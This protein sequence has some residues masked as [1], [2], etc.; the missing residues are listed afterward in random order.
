MIKRWINNIDAGGLAKRVP[1][2]SAGVSYGLRYDEQ[3]EGPEIVLFAA[4][5]DS[6]WV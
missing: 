6:L 1:V 2:R 3:G 4:E 5:P